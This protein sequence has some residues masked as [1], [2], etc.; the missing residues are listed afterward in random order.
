MAL[1]ALPQL[2]VR[3]PRVRRREQEIGESYC[4]T[5]REIARMRFGSK[6][7]KKTAL[8]TYQPTSV[9]ESKNKTKTEE[10][11]RKKS[12]V[13]KDTQEEYKSTKGLVKKAGIN[14]VTVEPV[15]QNYLK[16]IKPK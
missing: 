2:V 4:D 16:I 8:D 9:A 7:R 14:T 13:H 10:N 5:C 15:Y 11:S 3:R 1:Q 6:R 12:V